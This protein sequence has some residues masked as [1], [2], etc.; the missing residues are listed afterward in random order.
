MSDFNS[1]CFLGHNTG[2]P[3]LLGLQV[4]WPTLQIYTSKPSPRDPREYIH[5]YLF[6]GFRILQPWKKSLISSIY[7]MLPFHR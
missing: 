5:S 2:P 1:W 4:S 3:C 6:Q 7:L